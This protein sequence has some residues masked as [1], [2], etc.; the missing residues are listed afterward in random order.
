MEEGSIMVRRT[1]PAKDL[2]KLDGPWDDEGG[3]R[4]VGMEVGQDPA[5]DT[6]PVGAGEAEYGAA[7]VERGRGGD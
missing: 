5:E 7:G 1:R 6:E 2:P 3:I 4:A